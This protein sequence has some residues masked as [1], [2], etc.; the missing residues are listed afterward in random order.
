MENKIY[1]IA[2]TLIPNV[3]PVTARNLVSYCGSP[4]AVFESTKKSLLKIPGIGEQMCQYIHDKEV[5]LKAE[6]ELDFTLEH[7]IDV[8]FYTDKAYPERLRNLPDSPAL[9][10]YKGSI[11]LNQSRLVAIIGTRKPSPRGISICEELVEGLQPY[12]VAVVSGL[13]YG[14]DIT[15]HRKS[16]EVNIPTVGVLGHGMREIYPPQHRNTAGKMIEQGG[17]LTEYPGYMRPDREHFPM[18]NRIVAGMCDALIV[19]E[20]QGKGGSMITASIANN[21]NKDVFAVPGRVKDKQ[22]EGCNLLI[23]SHR[24]SLLESID[25]LAYIM[26][27]EALDAAKDVQHQLFVELTPDEKNIVDLL[28]KQEMMGIDALSSCVQRPSSQM[29]GLLLELEFKGII[30]SLPG[31]RYILV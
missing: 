20:T 25:D 14:I 3:G 12:G 31:N 11:P 9:L 8:L 29:A 17:L 30:R 7:H 22:S 4:Q 10:Y 21:Y 18:R 28:G 27:W 5:L 15:A 16:L 13:A 2:L 24:A 23:K 6:A 26:R 19:V 1:Q